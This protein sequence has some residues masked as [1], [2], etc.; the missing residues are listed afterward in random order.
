[1]AS[2]RSVKK[3][4]KKTKAS[5]PKVKVR[6][7]VKG[8]TKSRGPQPVRRKSAHKSKSSP[9][10]APRAKSKGKVK[11][12][13]PSRKT[14]RAAPKTKAGNTRAATKAASSASATARQASRKYGKNSQTAK[15]V[16]EQAREARRWEL[17]ARKS[18][19]LAGKQRAR[20]KAQ[21]ARDAAKLTLKSATAQ[22]T[23]GQQ[24]QRG[25]IEVGPPSAGPSSA[26]TY[27]AYEHARRGAG[28]VLSL[29]ES[30]PG[31]VGMR[32]WIRAS[33]VAN[34]SP[35]GLTAAGTLKPALQ[36]R[37]DEVARE[38]S[39]TPAEREDFDRMLIDAEYYGVELE[40]D[41]ENYGEGES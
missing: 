4:T 18:K 40:L 22:A 3:T 36:A 30:R 27:T 38:L 10:S 33:T 15:R 7:P 5:A 37:S 23:H 41:A 26:N 24:R 28:S 14:A 12:V 13:A 9:S 19:T 20:A 31:I 17:E 25:W 32:S 2:K 1:M 35:S 6:A 11:S 16:K 29:F 39:M 8:K 21:R 34:V